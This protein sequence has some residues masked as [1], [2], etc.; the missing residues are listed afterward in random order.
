MACGP[1]LNVDYIK[2]Q[3]LYCCVSAKA[4]GA[5]VTTVFGYCSVR[6]DLAFQALVGARGLPFEAELHVKSADVSVGILSGFI[7]SVCI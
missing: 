4:L 5:T 3:T 1:D 2:A 6:L 7:S